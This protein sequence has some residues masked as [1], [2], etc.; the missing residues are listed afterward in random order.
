MAVVCRKEKAAART[1]A[2]TMLEV[3]K[4]VRSYLFSSARFQLPC[5]CA[6]ESVQMVRSWR[7]RNMPP[8]ARAKRCLAHARIQH[9]YGHDMDMT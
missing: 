7:S 5:R 2:V 1:R 4:Q 6:A 3:V 8:A 9:E